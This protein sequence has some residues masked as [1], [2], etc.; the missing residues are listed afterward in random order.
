MLKLMLAP[1]IAL[2]GGGL[3]FLTYRGSK[4]LTF[5]LSEII[6]LL[7]AGAG[8]YLIFSGDIPGTELLR[9]TGSFTLSFRLDPTNRVFL[10]LICF[11]W[12]FAGLYAAEYMDEDRHCARFMGF[13]TVTFGITVLLC[14]S[15]NLFTLYCFYEMLTLITLPLVTHYEDPDSLRA[16]LTYLKYTVGGAALGLMGLIVLAFFGGTGEFAAGG[17]L[18]AEMAAGHET[19]LRGTFVAAFIGFSA[20]AAVFPL[21][22]WLPEA[23]VAPTPV[24]ALLHAV[25][26]VNAGAFAAIRLIY[27]AFGTELIAGTWA[28]TAVLLLSA[29]TLLYGAVKAIREQHLKR[30]LA[31]STVSNLSYMLFSACVMTQAGMTGALNHMVSH[32]LMKITLFFCAGIWLVRGGRA[33]LKDLN[34]IGRRMP[35][36]A[37]VFMLAAVALTGIP[38]LPGFLSKWRMLTA[39]V[40]LGSAGAIAGTAAMVTAAVMCCAY[41]IVPAVNMFFL[42][43]STVSRAK[44]ASDPGW[45]MKLTLAVLAAALIFL[46]FDSGWLTEILNAASIV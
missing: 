14:L 20:K 21:S 11:L 32:G 40:D 3:V 45:R 17:C 27:H 34:G 23:S 29:F 4:K 19:L 43:E 13:Y 46:S 31:W 18:N 1:L 22:R 30:R 16:G 2:L 38:P 7:T 10:G 8:V 42:S 25:A 36:T 33:E 39:A 35:F 28:Q 5:I 41:A 6:I 15:A 37:A 12:P 44:P 26:V 9:I 24:T